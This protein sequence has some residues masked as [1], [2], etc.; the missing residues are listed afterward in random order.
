ME[1]ATRFLNEEPKQE[2]ALKTDHDKGD[3]IELPKFV[4]LPSDQGIAEHPDEELGV[5]GEEEDINLSVKPMNTIEPC[6][7]KV[8]EGLTTKAGVFYITQRIKQ[9]L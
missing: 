3:I 7:R 4:N 8:A 6:S 1:L 2:F 5:I 9:H